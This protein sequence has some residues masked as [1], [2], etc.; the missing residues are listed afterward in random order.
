[1]FALLEMCNDKTLAN[2]AV[3]VLVIVSILVSSHLEIIAFARR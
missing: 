2:D 3:G 1:M